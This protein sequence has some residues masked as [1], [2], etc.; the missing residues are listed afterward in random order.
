MVWFYV[1]HEDVVF[2]NKMSSQN[3]YLENFQDTLSGI[4]CWEKKWIGGDMIK[5]NSFV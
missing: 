3:I 5:F 1:K 4:I 2:L